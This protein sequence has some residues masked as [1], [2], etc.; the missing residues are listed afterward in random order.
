MPTS[1]ITSKYRASYRANAIE[2]KGRYIANI[3]PDNKLNVPNAIRIYDKSQGLKNSIWCDFKRWL[4]FK[5]SY[6]LYYG[7]INAL[8][9]S[10]SCKPTSVNSEIREMKNSQL[11]QK[12]PGI[13]G[14][15]GPWKHWAL[16]SYGWFPWGLIYRSVETDENL[17]HT[18]QM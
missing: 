10:F 7:Y 18:W 6:I 17:G 16:T 13:W 4:S 3:G 11:S 5:M 15:G 14:P 8:K 9:Y 1:Q 2:M 12:K